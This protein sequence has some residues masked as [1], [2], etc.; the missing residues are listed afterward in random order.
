[1]GEEGR[2]GILNNIYIIA[3]PDLISAN[4]R[5]SNNETS[6]NIQVQERGKRPRL[7]RIQATKAACQAVPRGIH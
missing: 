6:L 7:Y 3:Q 4:I 5:K 1:M 2:G